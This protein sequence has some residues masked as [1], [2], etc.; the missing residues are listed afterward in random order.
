MRTPVDIAKQYSKGTV[1]RLE[2]MA[3]SV[4]SVDRRGVEGD[5]VECGVWMGGNVMLARMISPDRFCWLY[6]TFEGMPAPGP[7]DVKNKPGRNPYRASAHIARKNGAIM[8]LATVEEVTV[9]FEREGLLDFSKMRFVKGRV[10]DTLLIEE[11]LPEKI[12]V[13]RLDTDWHDSTKIELEILYPRLVSEG[14]LIIDDFGHW[15]GAHKAV[16]D[17]FKSAGID[18]SKLIHIDYTAVYMVKP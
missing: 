9:N 12:A 4:R 5:V 17:Y 2:A 10:E 7:Y 16:K 6:D 3:D 11:N 13:L 18:F 15:M 14:I 1:A 8:S